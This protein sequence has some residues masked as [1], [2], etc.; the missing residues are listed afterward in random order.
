MPSNLLPGLLRRFQRE[1][2]PILPRNGARIPVP[3]PSFG[4]EPGSSRIHTVRQS[5]CLSPHRCLARQA[6]SPPLDGL[7]TR[8]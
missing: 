2:P 7:G 4:P 5:L 1:S 8:C 3:E 6:A